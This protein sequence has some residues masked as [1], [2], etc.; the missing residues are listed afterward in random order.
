MCIKTS[1]ESIQ[2][3]D[4]S[5]TGWPI[6]QETWCF[7]GQFQNNL[8]FCHFQS[9]IVLFNWDI[10]TWTYHNWRYLNFSFAK[11]HSPIHSHSIPNST[12]VP[13]L[14]I[15]EVKLIR[16]CEREADSWIL[17]SW[18]QDTYIPASKFWLFHV[19]SQIEMGMNFN[20]GFFLLFFFTKKHI[21]IFTLHRFVEEEIKTSNR[22]IK[23]W[24]TVGE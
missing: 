13:R 22:K 23:S 1:V 16:H 8:S 14:L 19:C 15:Y 17:Q 4:L 11:L 10:F 3:Q 20:S 7:K 21:I 12:Q 6:W 2:I 9:L 24:K 18:V 5:S